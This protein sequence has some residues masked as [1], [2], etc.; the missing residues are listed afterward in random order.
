MC[1]KDDMRHSITCSSIPHQ[2][3]GILY[4]NVQQWDKITNTSTNSQ[5]KRCSVLIEKYA[6]SLQQLIYLNSILNW[7]F[8]IFGMLIG[9]WN[10]L[11]KNGYR[12]IQCWRIIIIIFL[13]LNCVKIWNSTGRYVVY[14]QLI[15]KENLFNWK[16]N[17]IGRTFMWDP[18]LTVSYCRKNYIEHVS[19]NFCF[20]LSFKYLRCMLHGTTQIKLDVTIFFYCMYTYWY[21]LTHLG[22]FLYGANVQY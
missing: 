1:I 21:L 8:N 4:F 15:G 12:T 5:Y 14:A 2:W 16:L 18:E 17:Q 7:T 3:N 19:I 9:E 22:W 13:Y 20:F 6:I 10:F 11:R